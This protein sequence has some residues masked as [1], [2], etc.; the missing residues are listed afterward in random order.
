VG[1]FRQLI[2][3]YEIKGM[4]VIFGSPV[5]EINNPGL[6]IIKVPCEELYISHIIVG[7]ATS[8]KTIEREHAFR[9]T[10]KAG[11]INYIGDIVIRVSSSAVDYALIDNESNTI[12]EAKVKYSGFFEKYPYVKNI[13]SKQGR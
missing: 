13:A 8:Q 7:N 6:K 1:Y 9:F 12:N 3:E 4:G 11:A 10:P 2:H 5:A